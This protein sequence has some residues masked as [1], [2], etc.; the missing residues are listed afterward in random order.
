MTDS[1][2]GEFQLKKEEERMNTKLHTE[3]SGKGQG[4]KIMT[5]PQD[6]TRLPGKKGRGYETR[7]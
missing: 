5:S 4:D 6:I 7:E 2:R 3:M 1:R